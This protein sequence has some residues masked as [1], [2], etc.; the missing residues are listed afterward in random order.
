MRQFTTL[1]FFSRA[2]SSSVK[3]KKSKDKK[4][5]RSKKSKKSRVS[6]EPIPVAQSVERWTQCGGAHR[7]TRT[8]YEGQGFEARRAL[9]VMRLL[10]VMVVVGG[11]P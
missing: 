6:S 4:E 5:K 9:D 7:C 10:A 11:R 1:A 8:G 3:S 2:S